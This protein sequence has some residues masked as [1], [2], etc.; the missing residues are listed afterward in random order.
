MTN[1]FN[2]CFINL[3]VT[4]DFGRSNPEEDSIDVIHETPLKYKLAS[5]LK[6]VDLGIKLYAE[7]NKAQKYKFDR[8]NLTF[9]STQ[10]SH[11]PL[12]YLPMPIT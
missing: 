6:L 5:A 12:I 9:L 4:A 7:P 1:F 2:D 3:P 10:K 11:V 8:S